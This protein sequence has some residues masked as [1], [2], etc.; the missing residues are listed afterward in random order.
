M[1]YNPQPWLNNVLF[2]YNLEMCRE[3]SFLTSICKHRTYEIARQVDAAYYITVN[4][5]QKSF[6]LNVA[7]SSPSCERL[8]VLN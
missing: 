5:K 3:D 1:A 7:I 4:L 8:I 2:I 6:L